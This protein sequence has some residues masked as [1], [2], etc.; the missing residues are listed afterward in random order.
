MIEMSIKRNNFDLLRFVFASV[1]F[2]VHLHTLSDNSHIYDHLASSLA[3]KSFFV[4]SGFLI[5]MSYERSKNLE[6]YCEKR[7]RRIYP[8]Y[9]TVVTLG[10]ILLFFV[11]SVSAGEYFSLDFLKYLLANLTFLNFLHPSL[12]GVFQGNQL[13]AVNGALWT[14]KI[15]VMFYAIVPGV[16]WLTRKYDRL[17]VIAAIYL[18][19]CL[20][21]VVTN[22]LAVSSGS[23]IYFKLGR[24][25]PGQLSYF[26]SG[27][28]FYYYSDNIVRRRVL[29]CLMAFVVM[30]FSYKFEV[31]RLFEPIALATLVVALAYFVIYFGY[32]SRFGDFSYGIY[33][34]HFPIVQVFVSYGMF[35]KYPYLGMLLCSSIVLMTSY[36]LW[37]CIE[38]PFLKK[39]SHYVL[40][41]K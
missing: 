28:L 15:E 37:H 8:G 12:P 22:H 30:V 32:F 3:V 11:S 36:L 35:L 1:V 24:Q 41:N 23:A 17:L 19:S 34:V 16:V 20:Y 29:Y 7:L 10:A 38:K 9:F 40:A 31:L 2:L 18:A 6:D 27:A 4:V 39:T 26:I 5:F 13:G 25:L 33:I 21:V 14:L